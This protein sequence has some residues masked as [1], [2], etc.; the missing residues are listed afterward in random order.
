VVHDH[1]LPDVRR[2]MAD[3]SARTLYTILRARIFD[4]ERL[5][6]VLRIVFEEAGLTEYLAIDDDP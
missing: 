3:Y 1:L 5:N 4:D 6:D 2:R